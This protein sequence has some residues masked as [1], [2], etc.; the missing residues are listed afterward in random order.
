MSDTRFV[1]VYERPQ[2]QWYGK[3]KPKPVKGKFRFPITV[4]Y[5]FDDEQQQIEYN[6]AE[7]GK[8]DHFCRRI[9]RTVASNRLAANPENHANSF[10][11]YGAV[12]TSGGPKYS[13]IARE[14][15]AIFGGDMGKQPIK[16]KTSVYARSAG[17]PAPQ[18]V[19]LH[20]PFA[21]E[22]YHTSEDEPSPELGRA[23]QEEFHDSD[24]D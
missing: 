1:Y 10:V 14:L 3:G 11:K 24:D 13:M 19:P 23:Y 8:K 15:V 18:T 20:D 21:A 22:V 4:A 7:C 12:S 16:K 2:Q 6:Y 5:R 9:G 17:I